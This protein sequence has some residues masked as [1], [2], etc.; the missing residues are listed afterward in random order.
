[1]LLKSLALA[2]AILILAQPPAFGQSDTLRVMIEQL[3]AQ[4]SNRERLWGGGPTV[5]WR[6]QLT[7]AV[8]ADDA[9]WP[10]NIGSI[11]SVSADRV[12]HVS[13]PLSVPLQTDICRMVD[14]SRLPTGEAGGS[15]WKCRG[16]GLNYVFFT[17]ERTPTDQDSIA[18]T[19]IAVDEQSLGVSAPECRS[20]PAPRNIERTLFCES[21]FDHGGVSGSGR[22]FVVVGST[23]NFF[24]KASTACA[25]QQCE[26]AVGQFQALLSAI[27]FSGVP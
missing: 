1:M 19:L 4:Q 21:R 3:S 20:Q 12:S 8:F 27:Q 26:A 22:M 6:P 23:P 7:E 2:G 5:D 14:F 25:G 17:F 18:R 11:G 13:L 15:A 16:A 10:S 9:S 24:F